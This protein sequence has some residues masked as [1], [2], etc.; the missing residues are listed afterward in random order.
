MGAAGFEP[1][2]EAGQSAGN[3]ARFGE[4]ASETGPTRGRPAGARAMFEE[5]VADQERERTMLGLYL[6]D[7]IL[8]DL[9][10]CTSPGGD[11]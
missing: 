5:G 3:D 10:A 2:S 9:P 4:A 11:A 7:D 8:G 1:G 6:E